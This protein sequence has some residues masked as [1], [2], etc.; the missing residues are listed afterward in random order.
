MCIVVGFLLNIIRCGVA[1]P[2]KKNR[3]ANVYA[4]ACTTHHDYHDARAVSGVAPFQGRISPSAHRQ[5]L[6][7][8]DMAKKKAA[9]SPSDAP[10]TLKSR[11]ILRK[12]RTLPLKD[13]DQ[14]SCLSRVDSLLLSALHW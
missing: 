12:A 1:L 6:R 5:R 9:V 11:C 3:T 14:H 8:G 13:L 7:L 4:M 10:A 2:K